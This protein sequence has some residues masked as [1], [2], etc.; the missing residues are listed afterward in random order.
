[1]RELELIGSNIHRRDTEKIKDEVGTLNV[2]VKTKAFQFSVP[3]SS[4][5]VPS[6]SLP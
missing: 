5:I 1:L 4:F 2:E 3:R 6:V